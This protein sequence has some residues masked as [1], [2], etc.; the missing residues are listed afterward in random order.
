MRLLRISLYKTIQD[1][2]I[3]GWIQESI[4]CGDYVLFLRPADAGNKLRLNKHLYHNEFK[5]IL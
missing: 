2:S 5:G 1:R 3:K 4:D